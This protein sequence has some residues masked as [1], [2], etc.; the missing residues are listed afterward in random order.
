MKTPLEIFRIAAAEFSEIDDDT[1][2]T[3]PDLTAP[4]VSRKRFGKVW[5]QALALLTAHRMQL[6]GVGADSGE[7]GG[8]VIDELGGAAVIAKLASYSSGGESIS[9]YHGA[10]GNVSADSEFELTEYGV[11]YLTLQKMC[12]IPIINAGEARC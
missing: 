3:R 1:L 5:V 9:F 4:L 8:S 7:G 10:S 6:A 11:Q 12:T 2:G